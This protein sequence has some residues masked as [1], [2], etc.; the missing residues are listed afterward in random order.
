[1][2]NQSRRSILKLGGASIASAIT[3][4]VAGCTS[5]SNVLPGSS[6][7]PKTVPEDVDIIA[8]GDIEA[9]LNDDAVTKFVNRYL[10]IASE[11]EYYEGPEDKEEAL[12]EFEDEAD[13]D[14]TKAK[15]ATAFGKYPPEDGGDY[16]PYSAVRFKAN[17]EEDDVVD[18]LEEGYYEFDDTTHEDKT[19]YEPD[20][21]Y[22]TV[23]MGVL[24]SNEFVLGTE[25]AVK[26]TIEVSVGETDSVDDD[27]ANAYDE[28][29]NEPF[30]FA[31]KVPEDRLPSESVE[32]GEESVNPQQYATINY[33]VGSTYHDGDSVGARLKLLADDEGDAEDVKQALEGAISAAKA[34]IEDEET[35]DALDSLTVSQDGSV[36]VIE[37]SKTVDEALELVDLVARRIF[38]L[39][40]QSISKE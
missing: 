35:K 29:E 2:T 31:S 37:A 5:V 34:E 6:S 39:E 27:F 10:E 15:T 8:H 40:A 21:E 13:L 1:M 11:N 14:M 19:L 18:A 4:S 25:P 17:W 30:R 33:V 7:A 28:S 32:V 22:Q 9:T 20:Q 26:E 36:V 23:W 38:G 3:T 24:G 16:D 12:E